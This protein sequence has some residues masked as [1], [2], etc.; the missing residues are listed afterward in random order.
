MAGVLKVIRGILMDRFAAS[1]RNAG[2][3]ITGI[4]RYDGKYIDW[5]KTLVIDGTNLTDEEV[6]KIYKYTQEL[7]C[8]KY[9]FEQSAK[10]FLKGA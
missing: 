9:E 10:E 7:N 6:D 8:G 1:W 5:L 3:V 4:P 2:G